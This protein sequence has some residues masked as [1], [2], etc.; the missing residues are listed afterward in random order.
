MQIRQKTGQSHS[1]FRKLTQSWKEDTAQNLIVVVVIYL[2]L[3]E[4]RDVGII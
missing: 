3:E 1:I 4:F 2:T